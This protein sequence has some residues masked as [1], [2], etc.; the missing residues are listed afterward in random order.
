MA[1]RNI[2]MV[3]IVALLLIIAGP[4]MVS[5][6]FTPEV[7]VIDQDIVDGSVNVT[8]ATINGDGWVVIHVDADGAPGD[9]IGY[10]HLMDGVNANVK[11]DVDAGAATDTLH[12][13]LHVDGGEVGAYEFPGPDE[14]LTVDDAIVMMPFEVTGTSDTVI[15]TARAAGGFETLLA[16]IDAAGLT[17]TLQGAGPFTV[18]APTDDAFAALPEGTVDALLEDVETLSQILTYH[19][20]PEKVMAADLADGQEAATVQGDNVTFGVGDDV[21]I[22]DAVI[23]ATDIEAAN[24]VIHVIDSVILPQAVA[25]ALGL[26]AEEA[27]PAEEEEAPEVPAAVEASRQESDGASVVVDMVE[28]AQDGW[29]S[30][31]AND[32][33]QPGAVLGVVPVTA[34]VSEG[35]EVPLD[36]ALS[37]SGM[38]FASLH[39]DDGEIGTFEFPDADPVAMYQNSP[40]NAPIQVVVGAEDAAPAEEEEAPEVPAAVE[41]SRQESDGA[42]VVVDMVEAAQ[43]GWLS[44]RANEGFQPGAV[45]GVVPVTAGV[46]EGVEVPLDEALSESGM[47]FASLHVD[48]GEIGTFEFPD[49]DPVAMYQNSPINAPIQLAIGAMAA[50]EA[51]PEPTEE[52]AEE[53]AAEATPEPTEEAAEEAA[54]EAT[55]EPTEEAA[56]EAACLDIVDTALSAEGFGTLVTAVQAAGLVETLK[57]EGPFTVFAPTDDAFAALPNGTL[58]SLLEDPEGALKE[59]L[60]YHVVADKLMAADIGKMGSSVTAQGQSVTFTVDGENVMVN[61][62]NVIGADIEACNGVIHV[63]DKVIVP[64]SAEDEEAAEEEAAAT[65]EPTEE[66]AEEAEMTPEATEEAAEE[67]V[68]TPEPTEEAAEE[69]EMTPEATEE[70]AEEAAAT[71]EP[72]EEAAEEAAMTPEAAEEA[73]ATP[74]PTEEAA[75]E[76]AMTPEPTEEAAEEAMAEAAATP[77]PTEEAMEE[78]EAPGTLPETGASMPTAA[79]TIPTVVLVAITLAGTAYVMRRREE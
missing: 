31:R 51:T 21:T 49:A 68:A 75:E 28:A 38:V 22:N 10:A 33:F 71:P 56:E 5:A 2:L 46:N 79:T 59:V 40:V 78:A 44:I 34:G 12:A 29:L 1:R 15:G 7:F 24:G 16:A 43:D 58:E 39:V 37:E 77:E 17:K 50:A 62:A 76:A 70:A 3:A 27:A 74:E 19:V 60:L 30:I 13:M 61:D 8:R 35:V 14:P 52:A 18:F 20:L 73:A 69:A 26:G 54:A 11:V 55:P 63:I 41:A 9:V 32:A 64:A 45:L 4:M 53:A 72:T 66:A 23:S 48:D 57:G 6:Q 47:V 67:A 42:S 36:E 65:P 25:E